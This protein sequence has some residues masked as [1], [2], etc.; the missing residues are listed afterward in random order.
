MLKRLDQVNPSNLSLLSAPI[1]STGSSTPATVPIGDDN[2][3]ARC[4]GR[5]TALPSVT[6]FTRERNWRSE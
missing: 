2:F 4:R 5:A 3:A 1:L 6:V